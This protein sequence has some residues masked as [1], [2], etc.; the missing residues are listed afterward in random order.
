V[1]FG[2]PE[3]KIAIEVDGQSHRTVLG[4][5]RDSKKDAKLKELGWRVFRITNEEVKRKYSTSK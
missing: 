1:D 2:N 5:Y 3:K 4:H